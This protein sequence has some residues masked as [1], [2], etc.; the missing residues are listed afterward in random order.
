[1]DPRVVCLERINIRQAG[2]DLLPEKVDLVTVDCSFISLR[3]VLPAC[4]QFLKPEGLLMG[5]VK[6]Q[7]EL[8]RGSTSK[9][10]VRSEELRQAAVDRVRV[11]AEERAGLC[12]QGVVPS[13]I[14]GPKGN[15]EYLALFRYATT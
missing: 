5:L 2:I 10:V 13:K 12:F 15:Q 9:G 8:E 14:K 11:F 7:F 3:V 6:P 4:L 1:M